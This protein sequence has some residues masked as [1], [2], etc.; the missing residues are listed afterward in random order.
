MLT[1]STSRRKAAHTNGWTKAHITADLQ[2]H[3]LLQPQEQRLLASLLDQGL[4]VQAEQL[5]PGQGTTKAL[6]TVSQLSP[7]DRL[8]LKLPP[9][10]KVLSAAI[11]DH[12]ISHGAFL[13]RPAY[14]AQSWRFWSNLLTEGERQKWR[15]L[16][17]HINTYTH[18]RRYTRT[19]T[20]HRYTCT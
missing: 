2:Q 12:E 3:L 15:V 13:T 20:T 19:Y 9:H 5:E 14:R 16:L 11:L 1:A 6:I 10:D 4:L 7:A 8:L 18:T 17:K